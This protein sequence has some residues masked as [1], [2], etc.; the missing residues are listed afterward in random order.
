MNKESV[1]RVAINAPL[2]RLFDYLPPDDGEPLPGCRVLVPFGR[3]KQIGLVMELASHS[4]IP[5]SKLKKAIAVLD[6]S[7]L[8]NDVD[9]WL[10]SFT[11]DY[12]H[13]PVGEVVAAALPALLRQGKPQVSLV[14]KISTTADGAS[15]DLNII[16]KR[17]PRQAALLT[18][19][20]DADSI[21]FDELDQAMPGWRRLKKNLA[22]KL[23]IEEF[24]TSDD[25]EEMET[26][27]NVE[28]TDGPELNRDQ[29]QALQ[30]IRSQAGFKVSLID[31]VTGSG[32]TEIYLQLIRDMIAAGRQVLV[33]VPE[34][35]LTPQLVKRFRTRLGLEPVLLHS[36]LTDTARLATWRAARRGSAQLILGTRSAVFVPMKAPGLIIVDEEHDSSLKQQEGLRYSARDL[37]I[38]RGKKQDIPVVMGSATPSL[39]SLQRC[40]EDA[41]QHL[42]LP[43]RAG[44][45]VPPLLR[46]VDLTKHQSSDGLSAPVISAITEN[47]RQDGQVLV[48]LN[49]RGFAPTLICTGCGKIADCSR[50][51]ARMTVHANRNKLM[52]HHCGASRAIDSECADCGSL[53]KPLGQGT[54]RLEDSLRAQFPEDAI[55]RIDSDSTRIK[56]TMKKALAAATTGETKIL[57]GTQMLSKGHHFPNLTLVVVINADQGLFSTDFRG[58]ERLA[59]SLIQVAGRS[60]REARQGE[61]IIQTAF[62][63]HPFWPE[64]FSGGYERVAAAALAEREQAAWPPFS[65]LALLRASAARRE[66]THAFLESARKIA[67]DMNMTDV[68]ILGPVSAPMER[69]AGRYRAQLLLQ[70]RQRRGL[71]DMLSHLRA[72]LEGSAS[73]RR[74]RW[75]I[76]VDPIE[77]F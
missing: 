10:I 16:R 36:A 77:L 43:S 68:R 7:P 6:D 19:I 45:A 62:P 30:A 18:I 3:Q 34:I 50:C 37:A 44:K 48:F 38:V 12:Y 29:A 27:A 64:L 70:S 60:G 39:E 67:E 25:S 58:S 74:V 33:L 47:I 73:A 42:P 11:S 61:V 63:Q 69:R 66:D 20:R 17:A 2:S 5:A 23:L 15:V 54:E 71:H 75:S 26:L 40:R 9:R 76:D 21:S 52:C 31:G 4:E 41:Y 55:T 32:K 24:V 65:R 28:Q 57:V 53:C 59:Q 14:S 46:L 8:L 49:R 13:H 56:G 51:D 22:D 72:T 1:M 35:G